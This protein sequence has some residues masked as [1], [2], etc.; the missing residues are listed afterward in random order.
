[1]TK[2]NKIMNFVNKSIYST[3]N[4]KGRTKKG[5]LIHQ[6]NIMEFMKFK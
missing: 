5:D 3:N 1:M 2:K 4:L 6:I